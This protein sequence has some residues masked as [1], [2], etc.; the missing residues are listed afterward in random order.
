MIC[1]GLATG[2]AI[3]AVAFGVHWCTD[4][5]TGAANYDW[6]IE[7]SGVV[8]QEWSMY[9]QVGSWEWQRYTDAGLM[10]PAQW[11]TTSP[12]IIVEAHFADA[13]RARVRACNDLGECTEFSPWSGSKAY[14][15]DVDG[16]GLVGGYEFNVLRQAPISGLR[17]NVFRLGFGQAV[18]LYP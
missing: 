2:Y 13:M 5:V 10:M 3:L 1:E 18:G 14:P 12:E 4:S 15:L 7:E 11:R 8:T 16:D 6:E 9:S 17:F